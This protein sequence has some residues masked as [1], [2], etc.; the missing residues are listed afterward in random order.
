[1]ANPESVVKEAAQFHTLSNNEHGV[2]Y[3]IEKLIVEKE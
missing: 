1:M 2:A 3:A